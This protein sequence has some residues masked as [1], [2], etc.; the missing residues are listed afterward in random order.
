M[1]NQKGAT[2]VVALSLLTIITLVAVYTIESSSIQVRM[3]SN[4]ALI[5]KIIQD[6]HNELLAVVQY[7][8]NSNSLT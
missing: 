4:R 1:K 2:L 7:Y 6:A 8:D 3:I 5:D